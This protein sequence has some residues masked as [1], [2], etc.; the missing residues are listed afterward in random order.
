MEH[1]WRQLGASVYTLQDFCPPRTKQD[2]VQLCLL[3]RKKNTMILNYCIPTINTVSG[4]FYSDLC[5]ILENVKLQTMVS[6]RNILS[7]FC[8]VPWNSNFCTCCF[9]WYT[10]F[11]GWRDRWWY[12][13]IVYPHNNSSQL[14]SIHLLSYDQV[15]S[16][17]SNLPSACS[18][19]SP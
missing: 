15:I 6:S 7:T 9:S 14:S 10:I 13:V 19:K 3:N 4:K 16:L 2:F 1:N 17:H 8:F 5:L 12:L 11:L 18:C